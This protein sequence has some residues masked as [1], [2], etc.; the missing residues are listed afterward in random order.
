M[1]SFGIAFN[2]NSKVYVT[3]TLNDH[4]VVLNSGFTF[5]DSFGSH[6]ADQ[7]QFSCPSGI[8]CDSEGKMYIVDRDNNCVRSSLPKEAFGKRLVGMAG[9]KDN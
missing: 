6:G 5:F 4:I 8:T 3:D 9:G 7:E 1:K 2:T